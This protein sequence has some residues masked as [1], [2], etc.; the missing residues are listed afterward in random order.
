MAFGISFGKSKTSGSSSTD[1][2]KTEATNQTQTGTQSTQGSTATTGTST[3]QATQSGSTTGATSNQQATTGSQTQQ[4]QTTQFSAPVLGA[5]ESTVQSLLGTLPG[6]PM[7]QAGSFDHQAFVSQGVEA[8]Q[9]QTQGELENSLN[10]IFD[11]VGGRDDQNSMA[12]L[13]ANRAR[14]DAAASVAGVRSQLEGQ[15]QNI[16][17]QRFQNNLAG[18]GQQEG[19]LSQVLAALKGGQSN[20]T[21]ATQTAEQ[22]AGGTQQVGTSTQTGTSSTSTAQNEIVNQITQLLQNLTGTT[23]TVGK[24]DTTTKGKTGG[25]GLGL[26]I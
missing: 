21:A 18:V 7:T 3:T 6:T 8:A 12:T 5:L 14:G 16:D 10:S 2:N 13:L 11:T 24:E 23:T 1:V 19:F 20:T 9:A 25:F 4:Q 17:S 26:A 22:T 15:A